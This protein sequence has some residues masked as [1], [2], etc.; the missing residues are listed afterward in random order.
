MER[1]SAIFALSVTQPWA[2]LIAW[3]AKRIESRSWWTAY[4]GPLAIHAAKD[5]P[6]WARE[7]CH[8]EL[9]IREALVFH[10]ARRLAD[11]P[12]GAVLATCRLVAC[13]PTDEL[14]AS[15]WGDLFTVQ[16]RAYG[17][18]APGRWAWVLDGVEEPPAPVPAV[19]ALGLWRWAPP[20]AGLSPDPSKETTDG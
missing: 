4:R 20:T 2:S 12:R 11:L 13:V 10:G 8:D 1:R 6:R 5:F 3:Q 16:E 9:V 7:L 17:D 19:G 15:A 14:A 18:Y